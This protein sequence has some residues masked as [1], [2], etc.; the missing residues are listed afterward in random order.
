M[1]GRAAP[2]ALLPL[3]ATLP[4][5]LGQVLSTNQA[6]IASIVVVLVVLIAWKFLKLAFKIA[7]VVAAAIAIYLALSWAGI[8]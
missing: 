7:L 6:V 3:L 4:L 8:L 5:V 1:P 2:R